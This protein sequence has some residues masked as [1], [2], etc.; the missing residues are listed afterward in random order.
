MKV[1]YAHL[2]DYAV[3]SREGKLSVMGIFNR[4]N[5]K[6]LPAVHPNACLAFEIELN[7]AEVNREI[8]LKIE[9]VD[10]DGSRLAS[11][12][13][14]ITVSGARKI[15]TRPRVP[16]IIRFSQMQF[17][18][19]GPYNVNIWLNE[20]LEYQLDLAVARTSSGD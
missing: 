12:D 1:R 5:S 15:G 14:A 7:H 10:A 18:A 6:Q 4:I 8:A 11:I 17:P 13:G 16:Q 19:E 9:V 20:R 3:I 2:C